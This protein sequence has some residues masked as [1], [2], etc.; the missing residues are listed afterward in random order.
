MTTNNN[1]Q[2]TQFVQPHELTTPKLS[3]AERNALWA[4][5]NLGVTQQNHRALLG[6]NVGEAGDLGVFVSGLYPKQTDAAPRVEGADYAGM[7][8]VSKHAQFGPLV[9]VFRRKADAAVRFTIW[10]IP[11]Q[12]YTTIIPDGL[13]GFAIMPLP[14]HESRKG[15]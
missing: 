6:A 2:L 3:P 7:P 4:A 1:V 12:G 14:E 8:G 11:R 13:E 10:S 15:D 9:K 5:L